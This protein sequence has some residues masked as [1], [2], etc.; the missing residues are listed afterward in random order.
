MYIAYAYTETYHVK[1]I[2]FEV[3]LTLIDIFLANMQLIKKA[4]LV[5]MVFSRL[6]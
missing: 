5:F 1:Q 2:K 6:S 4:S 3:M